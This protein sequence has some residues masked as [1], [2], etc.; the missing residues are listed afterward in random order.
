M[1]QVHNLQDG[2][3]LIILIVISLK[4]FFVF[5]VCSSAGFALGW[6]AAENCIP[7][8]PAPGEPAEPNLRL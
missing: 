2:R 4:L 6:P 5:E 8:T 1:S 3:C 7:A